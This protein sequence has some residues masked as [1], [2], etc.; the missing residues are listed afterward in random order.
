MQRKMEPESERQRFFYSKGGGNCWEE[1][2]GNEED[3]DMN[4]LA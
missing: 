4:F 3:R 2:W 1:I